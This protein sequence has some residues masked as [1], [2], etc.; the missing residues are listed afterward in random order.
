MDLD[1]PLEVN[2]PLPL[3]YGSTFDDKRD[4]E[5]WEKSNRM[6]MMIMKKANLK[7]F[8]GSIFEKL[9]MAKEFFAEI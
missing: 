6:C 2:Y 8:S 3:T 1:V 9:T 7:P 4:M 5:R